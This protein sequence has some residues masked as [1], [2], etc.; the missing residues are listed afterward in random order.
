MHKNVRAVLP[1]DKAVS[2]GVV[3]PLHRAFQAFHVCPLGTYPWSEAVP[4]ICPIVRP[5]VETVKDSRAPIH[6]ACGPC[7]AGRAKALRRWFWRPRFALPSPCAR[8][9]GGEPNGF[10]SPRP[11]PA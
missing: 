2:F 9:R 7:F 6:A 4:S 3:T 8:P 10:Q 1:P 11:P 5:F